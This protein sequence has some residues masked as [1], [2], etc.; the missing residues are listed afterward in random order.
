MKLELLNQLNEN[1]IKESISDDYEELMAQL[2]NMKY[3]GESFRIMKQEF[4]QNE[5]ETFI[6][7]ANKIIKATKKIQGQA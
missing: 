6:K 7:I 4:A 3:F 2:N 5:G 1:D